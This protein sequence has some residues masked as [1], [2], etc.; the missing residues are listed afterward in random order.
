VLSPNGGETWVKGMTK[1][2]KWSTS[3][4]SEKAT[5]IIN[6][7]NDCVSTANTGCAAWYSTEVLRQGVPNT[8]SYS[9]YIPT[10]LTDGRYTLK[11]EIVDS[12]G[13]IQDESD[14]YFK[15][16]KGSRIIGP[17]IPVCTNGYDATTGF[18]CGCTSTKGYSSTTGESCGM[19]T[20]PSG[21]T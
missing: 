6:K 14:S 18:I 1:T 4:V 15:I 7:L 11:I 17:P 20:F 13:V 12:S 21:C 10:T 16:T 19:G 2:I 3:S 5:I 9:W 8:G